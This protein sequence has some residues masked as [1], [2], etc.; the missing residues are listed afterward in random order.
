MAKTKIINLGWKKFLVI[1]L[2]EPLR[3]NTKSYP[4]DPKLEKIIFSDIKKTGYE[5]Y[6]YKIG[7]HNFHPHGDAPKHQNIKLRNKGFESF[8]LNYCFNPACLIDLSNSKEAKKVNGIKYLLEIKKEHLVPFSKII[9]RK[10]AVLIRTGYDKW[11]EKNYSHLPDKLPY[12]KEETAIFLSK[13]KNL[14][15]IGVD[16]LTIDPCGS[17][18]AHQLFKNLLIVESIVGL[19]NIPRKSRENFDLQTSPVKIK[20]ATGGPIVA[21]AFVEL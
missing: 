19:Y 16:S 18:F 13:F 21:Y 4:G 2:T 20:G 10:K 14:K 8:G 11:I 7:D 5:H 15:V 6:I 9:P 3:E 1:D 12:L 17:H